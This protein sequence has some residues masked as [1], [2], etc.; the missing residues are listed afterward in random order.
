M[1][2]QIV[3]FVL[4]STKHIML[5]RTKELPNI[6]INEPGK[7][8]SSVY[9]FGNLCDEP[10]NRDLFPEFCSRMVDKAYSLLFHMALYCILHHSA[11][12]THVLTEPVYYIQDHPI[13]LKTD[14]GIWSFLYV[15]L[16]F[17]TLCTSFESFKGMSVW[18]SI[19]NELVCVPV[20]LIKM[21]LHMF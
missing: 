20:V 7:S 14:F 1:S 9:Y 3:H 5:K 16:F 21:I 19:L 15:S 18:E 8:D 6:T 11:F 17:L 10:V 12:V 13:T 4:L 2:L